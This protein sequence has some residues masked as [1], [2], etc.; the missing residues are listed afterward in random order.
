MENI[1]TDNTLVQAVRNNNLVYR[2]LWKYFTDKNDWKYNNWKYDKDK[3][4][5][6]DT[7][8]TMAGLQCWELEIIGQEDENKVREITKDEYINFYIEQSLNVLKEF[9]L[10][11]TEEDIERHKRNLADT[12]DKRITQ[13]LDIGTLVSCIIHGNFV[14]YKGRIYF[15]DKKTKRLYDAEN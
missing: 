7:Y 2:G 4:K 15:Q 8:D 11:C 10:K 12:Y 6:T 13:G 1:I 3:N 5:F 14:L 9:N